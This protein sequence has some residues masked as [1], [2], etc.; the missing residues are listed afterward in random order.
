MKNATHWFVLIALGLTASAAKAAEISV[1]VSAQNPLVE[2]SATASSGAV[3]VEVVSEANSTG[4]SAR[5]RAFASFGSL[6]VYAISFTNSGA[7]GSSGGGHAIWLDM[8]TINAPGLNG[9]AGFID[10]SLSLQGTLSA[11]T[12]NNQVGSGNAGYSLD[13]SFDNV[14]T[15][16]SGSKSPGGPPTGD[17]LP[18]D[19]SILNQ[20]FTFG[21][22]FRL[23]VDLGAGA[24]SGC[25][26]NCGQAGGQANLQDTLN[27]GG[28]SEVRDS[29]GG[30]VTNFTLSSDSGTDWTQP[31]P[32]P[33]VVT[34]IFLALIGSCRLHPISR[35]IRSAIGR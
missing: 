15:S 17:L 11:F 20:P 31:V 25:D 16:F 3:A 29:N 33:S 22:P 26:G 21:V 32:E 18:L 13:I 23:E 30:S 12:G 4:G 7:D 34:L 19:V 2:D 10:F 5:A 24:G 1:N 6:S 35:K 27:W 9:T 8:I 14:T 28:I